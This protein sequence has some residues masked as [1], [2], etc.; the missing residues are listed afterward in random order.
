MANPGDDL[1]DAYV[2]T[3]RDALTVVIR[4]TFEAHQDAPVQ[5]VMVGLRRELERIGL[6]ASDAWILWVPK[7]SSEGLTLPVRIRG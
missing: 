3:K 7:T 1:W 6:P 4:R 2:E 5:E